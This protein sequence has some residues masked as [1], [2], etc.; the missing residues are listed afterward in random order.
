MSQISKDLADMAAREF[1]PY[2]A[3]RREK[4]QTVNVLKTPYHEGLGSVRATLEVDGVEK[5]IFFH[6]GRWR[7]A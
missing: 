4:G 2:V 7:S 3:R 6:N 5:R 1:E